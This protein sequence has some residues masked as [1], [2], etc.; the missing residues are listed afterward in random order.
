MSALPCDSYCEHGGVCDLDLGHEGLHDSRYCQWDDAH[1][2][3]KA[4]ADAVLIAKAPEAA[5]ITEAD[6]ALRA[7]MGQ[8][9]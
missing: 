6:G 5:W 8:E 2:L 9:L 1:A 3:S 7:A 4:D